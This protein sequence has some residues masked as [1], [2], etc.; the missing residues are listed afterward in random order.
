MKPVLLL[1]LFALVACDMPEM[2]DTDV[3]APPE[4][5]PETAT[6][7]ALPF[8]GVGYRAEGDM[9]QLIG[10][11][12]YTNQFLDDAADFVGCPEDMENLGVFV[13]DT[14]AIPVARTQGYALFTVPRR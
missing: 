12:Y 1:A 14:G 11:N 6:T 5:P 9:C 7:E 3:P 4:L 10:E 2:S 8:S 13:A